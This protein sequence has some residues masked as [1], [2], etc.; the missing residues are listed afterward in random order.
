LYDVIEHALIIMTE[1]GGIIV[2]V[3]DAS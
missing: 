3:W 2:V 1:I